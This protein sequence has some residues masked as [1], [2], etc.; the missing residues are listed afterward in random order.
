[1]TL[2]W[3][4]ML[5][6]FITGLAAL[7][8]DDITTPNGETLAES[9]AHTTDKSLTDSP[10]FSPPAS[11]AHSV[12]VSNGLLSWS[13]TET[14]RAIPSSAQTMYDISN[15]QGVE[16][17]T[18]RALM[19][20]EQATSEPTSTLGTA[21]SP[22][23]TNSVAIISTSQ[24][25]HSATSKSSTV[26][27]S[28]STSKPSTVFESSSTSKPSTVFESS[29]TSKP[30]TVFESSSTSKPST[31]FESSSTSK[32][33]TV[34]ESSSTSKS[35]T[36]FESSS[37]SKPSTTIDS[38]I[39]SQTANTS[40]SLPPKRAQSGL[41]SLVIII[42]ILIVTVTLVV[43]ISCC[44]ARRKRRHSQSFAPQRK[45]KGKMDDAWAG[46]VSLPEDGGPAEGAEEKKDEDPT[47]K[48]MSLS[49]S[50][51]FG[52]RKSRAT[53]VLLE[54]VSL[55][56]QDPLLPNGQ[57]TAGAQSSGQNPGPAAEPSPGD[58]T[59]QMPAEQE[60]LLPP[61]PAFQ[62]N[63]HVSQPDKVENWPSNDLPLPPPLDS[64]V[65]SIPEG[66]S[67]GGE[68]PDSSSVKTSF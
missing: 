54:E 25:A 60:L 26:F 55:P 44:L 43:L 58:P 27:E 31:V 21:W 7:S 17:S 15:S 2:P 12:P 51:F 23:T 19:G 1:M 56:A 52:K 65:L 50:T 5:F 8:E 3:I 14:S 34:F 67:G 24:P 63:G 28:S 36:V 62:P 53:S 46:P 35:S 61:S 9:V 30:S 59:I 47:S 33:S 22:S 20:A 6:G 45:K 39:Q 18:K 42:I 49:T 10:S 38:S 13:D 29:S 66:E 57:A 32:S 64:T 37:T 16:L 68:R 11:M 40:T 41:S 48:R 4:L